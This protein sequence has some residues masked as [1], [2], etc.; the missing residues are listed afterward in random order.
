MFELKKLY[1]GNLPWLADR[2]IIF[3][4]AGS[5][6]YGLNTPESDEDFKGIAVPTKEY[7]LGFLKKFEQ[8]EVKKT[9]ESDVEFVIYDIR[10]FFNLASQANPNMIELLYLDSDDYLFVTDAGHRLIEA[11]DLFLSKKIV[12]TYTGY[13]ASQLKRIKLH[14]AHLLTPP[15]KEP[16]REDFG[17]PSDKPLLSKDQQGAFVELMD[18]GVIQE[19]EMSPNFL[20]ALAKEKAYFQAR[21]HWEQYQEWKQN[22]NPKRAELEE[23][24]GFDTKHGMHLYR[25]MIQAREILTTGKLIVKRKDDREEMLSI[26]NGAWSYDKLVEWAEHQEQELMEIAKTSKLPKEPNSQK[27]DMLCMDIV[28]STLCQ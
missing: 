14:R 7:L 4:R 11:R 16:M 21:R 13:S 18:K 23:R 17:L 1:R 2:T 26:R 22:R 28:E 20:E 27:L 15:K 10:K 24:F 19:N 9:A 12:Y 6:S 3:G 5:H 8:A 25:L